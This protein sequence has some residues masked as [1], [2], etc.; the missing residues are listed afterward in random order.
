MN[1]ATKIA[2]ALVLV[3]VCAGA[4][5][6]APAA[7]ERVAGKIVSVDPAAKTLTVQAKDGDT[8]VKVHDK[9][10][11]HLDRPETL[12]DIKTKDFVMAFGKISEDKTSIVAT[13]VLVSAK[14]RPALRDNGAAGYATVTDGVVSIKAD[15]QSLVVTAGPRANIARRSALA[16]ADVKP[17]MTTIVFAVAGTDVKMASS[18]VCSPEQTSPAA[19]KPAGDEDAGQ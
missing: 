14:G 17:G 16:L 2:I 8:T 18:V 9:T 6:Q 11:I 13:R 3:G 19:K 1:T 7:V 4:W 15:T 12:K 10:A 5:T